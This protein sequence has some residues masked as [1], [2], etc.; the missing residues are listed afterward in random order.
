MTQNS[1][2]DKSVDLGKLAE[3]TRNYSGAEIEG[4]VASAVSFALNRHL[5]MTDLNKPIDDENV[6]VTM[7]DFEHAL[8]EVKP[9]FGAQI[10]TLETQR[11]HGIISYGTRFEH[12]QHTCYRLVEQVLFNL[13][14]SFYCLFKR[15]QNR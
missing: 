6:K 15:K 8:E 7:A 12:L 3:R 11:M 5:D 1:F 13:I 14:I 10:D 4:L 9:A 2:A